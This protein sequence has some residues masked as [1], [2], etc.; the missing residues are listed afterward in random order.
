MTGSPV[1]AV[2]VYATGG[3]VDILGDRE[4]ALL[5]LCV[6]FGAL[7]LALVAT[8]EA[9]RNS[10]DAIRLARAFAQHCDTDA[11]EANVNELAHRVHVLEAHARPRR[12]KGRKR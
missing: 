9:R 3:L 10:R 5:A 8:L 12:T 6:G 7:G 1:Q 2:P 4:V 11:H